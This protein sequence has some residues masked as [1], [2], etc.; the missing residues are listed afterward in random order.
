MRGLEQKYKK[1]RLP[2]DRDKIMKEK[3][4]TNLYGVIV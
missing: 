4:I 1:D 2:N 3:L